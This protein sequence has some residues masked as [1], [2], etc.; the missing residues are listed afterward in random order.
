MESR[1]F[2]FRAEPVPQTLTKDVLK[3]F[4]SRRIKTDA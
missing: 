3:R 2:T 4:A 1:D